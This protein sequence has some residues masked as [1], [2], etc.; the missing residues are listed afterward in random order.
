MRGGLGQVGASV[1]SL[2]LRELTKGCRPIER[3][4]RRRADHQEMA[5]CQGEEARGDGRVRRSL[6]KR[7]QFMP[8]AE[9]V[10][11]AREQAIIQPV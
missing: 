10:E 6:S 3:R 7:R 4:V 8:I 5:P 1:R 11:A 2:R 9:A